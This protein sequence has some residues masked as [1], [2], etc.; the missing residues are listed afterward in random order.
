MKMETL[1]NELI[2]LIN[3]YPSLKIQMTISMWQTDFL[4]F[5]QS[6]T[7]YNIS[8]KE[9]FV[10]VRIYKDK[11]CYACGI[12]NPTREKVRDKIEQALDIIDSL[13][14]DPDFIDLEK[15]TRKA[16][17]ETIK[18]NIIQLPLDQKIDILKQ[19]AK[20]VEPFDFKIYG[21][22]VCNY[23]T[24]YV[25]NSNG[26]DKKIESSPFLLEIKAVSNKNEVTVLETCGGDNIGKLV[27][28]DIIKSIVNK[29]E[30]A[31]KEIVDVEPG[32]YEVI[33]A[34]RCINDLLGYYGWT[35]LNASSIDQKDTDLEGKIGEKIFPE[36]FTL[37]DDP[38]NPNVIRGEYNGDGHLIEPLPIIENGVFKN[39]YVDNYYA[40][41][42][43]MTENGNQGE[44]LVLKT[45]NKSLDEMISTIKKGLYISSLHYMNFINT[46]ES[47]LTGLTRDGTFLIED[48]KITKVVNNLR[49][50]EK[51][52]NVINNTT[53]IE[54]KHYTIPNSDNYGA[55]SISAQAMP[56]IKV[57]KF[58]ISSSTKTI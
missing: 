58:Q 4:R 49:F 38:T 29:V 22:F 9:K 40:N 16:K 14:P 20:A 48:G 52:T 26:V 42:L 32:Y 55:F 5:F 27:L 50:T 35:S 57:S 2:K 28:P 23:A 41:K 53:E 13:P 33:L 7:N 8:K 12:N 44:Y 37:I 47:S 51:I 56:H 19:V 46:R 11:K 31:T 24:T 45:G 25:I 36:N 1:K 30:S 39:F 10:Y 34:P 17:E 43:S 54:N 6:Q 15:D 21:T 3:D 18:N